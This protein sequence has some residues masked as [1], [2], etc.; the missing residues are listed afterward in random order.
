MTHPIPERVSENQYDKLMREMWELR[1]KIAGFN[2]ISKHQE[3]IEELFDQLRA[4]KK[5][6]A[7]QRRMLIKIGLAIF[8]K[9]IP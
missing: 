3:E 2:H 7:S 4:I 9:A 6:Q 5:E 8:K 1:Q